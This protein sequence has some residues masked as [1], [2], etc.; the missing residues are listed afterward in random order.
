MAKSAGKTVAL[1]LWVS[2]GE[3]NV[4]NQRALGGLW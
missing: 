3:Q 4:E 2:T 1:Y